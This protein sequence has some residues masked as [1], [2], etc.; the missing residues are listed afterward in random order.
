[1][2]LPSL[3]FASLARA[4]DEGLTP[5]VLMGLLLDRIAACGDSGIFLSLT[6][7]AQLMA[8]ARALQP[9]DR[10]DKRLW[11]VPFAV[12]DNI[13][14]AGLPTTAGCPAY[15][16]AP[17]QHAACVERLIAAG[18]LVLG[19]TNLDQFATGL[20]G[21]RTPHPVPR[22]AFDAAIVPGGSSSG[23]AGAVARGLASFA[24][25]TDTAG[26]GRVPAALN[27]L[28]GVKP[29][30]G[31]VSTRGVVPA[32]RTLDCVSVF[33]LT[34][35]DGFAVLCAMAGYD[36]RDP[37][38]KPVTLG[39][40]AARP[41]M[42][43]LG[44][45]DA[46][47]RRFGGDALSERAF[48]RALSDLAGLG[49]ELVEIDLAPFF[50]VAALLYNG[51]FVAE[52]YAATRAI[53]ETHPEDMLPVT[54]GV[55]GGATRFSAADAFDGLYRLAELRR[56]TDATWSGIDALVLPSLP[57]PVRV[58]ELEADPLGPNAELGTY[59]NFVN[60]LDL[61]AVATPGRFRE[62]GFP[63]GVTLAAPA[64]RDA[65][66]A[67]IAA[68]L[69][70][71]VGVPLGATG[72]PQ[73]P[74]PMRQTR[75]REGEVELA[76]VGAH[77]SGMALNGELLSN[78]GRFLRAA[79]TRST[80]RLYA[81]PGGPPR[82]PGLLRVD[83]DRGTAIACEVWALPP[84]GFGRFVAT[85]PAP[86]GIGT[87]RLED[88]TNPKGFLVENEGVVGAEDVSH[89]GGWRSFVRALAA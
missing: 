37:F 35:D 72:H 63:S 38:S 32:C 65:F 6:E 30:L 29:T 89:H 56:K 55:I 83:A 64:G 59:T 66:L 16:Y 12:K 18:A 24:L 47:S 70:A 5:E 67:S 51:P 36:A 84:E 48:N 79:Q 23:A 69:H 15:A 17:S 27:N 77:M 25:G 3:D 88:G 44:V 2:V 34:A 81:L 14:I 40:L 22:N 86:L 87:L 33:A 73:P 60:L 43:R 26:A 4:Y 9:R 54:R 50:A 74:V 11:G 42:L 58:A 21:V 71:A 7:P 53:M 82:R 76:V 62:N 1:M 61:C 46:S 45:P 78:G 8:Q 20:V 57:R 80:Y 85:I 52:R 68:D 13:D 75:A 49:A 10:A 19:K 28:V 31:A 41:P 39:G